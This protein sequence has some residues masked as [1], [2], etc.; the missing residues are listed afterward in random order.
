MRHKIQNDQTNKMLKVSLNYYQSTIEL[1]SNDDKNEKEKVS[2]R[3]KHVFYTLHCL[4]SCLYCINAC[5]LNVGSFC[6]G[7]VTVCYQTTL[8]QIFIHMTQLNGR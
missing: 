5:E 1:Q 3:C 7:D 4:V 8:G 2:K 6:G